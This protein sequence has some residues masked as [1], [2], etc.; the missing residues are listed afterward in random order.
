M[1]GQDSLLQ[2]T[3]E[4][5]GKTCIWCGSP[6]VHTKEFRKLSS[7]E[8]AE[9]RIATVDHILPQS[10]GGTDHIKNLRPSCVDCNH[11]RGN[12]WH[13]DEPDIFPSC[14]LLVLLEIKRD[15]LRLKLTFPNSP[16]W[17]DIWADRLEYRVRPHKSQKIKGTWKK[18]E[19]E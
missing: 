6:L 7:K 14:P 16:R 5:Y 19:K 4:A 1:S 17:H 9:V 15:S 8:R 11:A 3:L 12:G 18:T 2:Q 13:P 10:R